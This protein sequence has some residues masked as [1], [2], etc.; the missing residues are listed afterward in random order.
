ML[1]GL[2]L[3]GSAAR[4]YLLAFDDCF[5]CELSGM[6]WSFS[7]D[8]LIQRRGLKSSLA[9]F[10]EA[11]LRVQRRTLCFDLG[12]FILKR[13]EDERPS[14]FQALIEEHGANNGF[15]DV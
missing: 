12:Q 1:L 5:Y 6:I 15:V 4:S 9:E 10:L 11:G 7:F 3:A 8:E 13:L 2:L 14:R